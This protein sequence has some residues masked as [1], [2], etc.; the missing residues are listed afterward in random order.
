[1]GARGAGWMQKLFGGAHMSYYL[2]ETRMTGSYRVDMRRRKRDRRQV[3]L[4]GNVGDIYRRFG[5]DREMFAFV[6][7]DD[8]A[9]EQRTIQ[10]I[11]DGEN[12]DSFGE[13]I[14]FAGIRF[15]RRHDRSDAV[16]EG[17]T[18]FDRAAFAEGGNKQLFT[19][20][21]KKD[22]SP[23]WLDYELQEVWSFRGGV[24]IEGEWTERST[25]VVTL[26]PPYRYRRLEV[27]ADE[28]NL[29]ASDVLRVAVMFRH[30]YR[31]METRREVVLR[32]G[33]P[34]NALYSYLTSPDDMEYEYRMTFLMR[35]GEKLETEWTR[36]RD[37]V[38]YAYAP[39]PSAAAGG[40][41]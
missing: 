38:V 12:L 11:L 37:P 29:V 32:A 4:T 39:Q 41:E 40:G 19:Y 27:L 25:D 7:L 3:P 18:I 26:S 34:L 22:Q 17:S 31:G 28:A 21:R 20:L 15:R 24:E 10:V 35:D 2:R 33:E 23:G 5:N 9:F 36:G 16:T 13:F 30:D 8:P 14:N 1:V 6:D